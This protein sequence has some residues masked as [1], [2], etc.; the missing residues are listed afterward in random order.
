MNPR[1]FLGFGIAALA[2]AA[3]AHAQA[4][5]HNPTS[6]IYVADVEGTT[7]ITTQKG[8]SVLAKKEVYKGEG[9]VFETEPTSNAAI[10]MSNGTGVYFDVSTRASVLGFVQAP[11]RP[12]RTDMEEEPSIS[13]THILISYG[14]S[15]ISTSKMA[16]G[17]TLL[18]DTS[19]ATAAIEGRQAVFQVGD[20][21][22]IISMFQGDATVQAGPMS[23]AYQVKGGQEIIVRP[24]KPGQPNSVEIRE[25]VDGSMEGQRAWLYERVLTADAAR[26]LV[27]F[28]MQSGS[29]DSITLFDGNSPGQQIVAV[30]VVPVNP[31]VVPTV[32]AAN[33]SGR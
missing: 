6:K 31:P 24:G 13:R 27:Y 9:T 10:V 2:I 19:L 3:A 29:D 12:N 5:V 16:A 17:S 7:K 23:P 26:K 4:P 18:V 25:V 8:I 33:L 20:N 30:P 11:F 28:E 15:G 22:T 1:P 14:V 21:V 32:S